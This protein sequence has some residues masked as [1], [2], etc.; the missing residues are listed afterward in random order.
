MAIVNARRV[1]FFARLF[2]K[3]IKIAKRKSSLFDEVSMSSSKLQKTGSRKNFWT[4]LQVF[5]QDDENDTDMDSEK[6]EKNKTIKLSPIKVLTQNADDIL[7]LLN[8]KGVTKYLIKRMSIGLKI[9]CETLE[10]YN[11]I[12]IILREN[13][14]QFFT[15]ENKN[16]KPF[17]VILRGLDGKSET[18]VKSEL[19]TL[20]LE[21]TEVKIVKRNFQNYFDTIYIVYFKNGTIKMFDLKK[22]M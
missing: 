19:I 21:C 3:I 16:N 9:L 2:F 7:K 1:I 13:N 12:L 20:G 8:N 6:E 14:C 22:K 17:K 10:T 4:P 11:L 5:D 15:H 18:Q